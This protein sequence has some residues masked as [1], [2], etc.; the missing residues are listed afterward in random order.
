[1]I[2]SLHGVAIAAIGDQDEGDKGSSVKLFFEE[3]Q[4]D[5]D[6]MRAADSLILRFTV[7][8]P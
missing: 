3:F 2:G 5:H 4:G 8:N 1:M 7:N 6:K